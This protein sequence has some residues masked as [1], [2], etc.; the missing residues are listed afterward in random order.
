M[1]S[2][3]I[4]RI[5][6]AILLIV[7]L[8]GAAWMIYNAGVARGIAADGNFPGITLPDGSSGAIQ[9]PAMHYGYRPFHGWGFGFF[10]FFCFFPLLFFFLIF[11]FT[12]RAF[13]WGGPHH[14]HGWGGPHE[15]PPPFEEWHRKAHEKSD[16][17]PE[18]PPQA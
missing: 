13:F 17:N 4:A 2:R 15:A 6:A 8:S 16:K 18:E 7:V 11:A 14:H 1:N 10:P 5:L 3:I 9:V 12:R